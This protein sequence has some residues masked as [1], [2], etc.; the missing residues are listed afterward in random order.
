MMAPEELGRL[1]DE[2]SAA[3]VLFARQWTGAPE[4]VVQ[5][6]FVKRAGSAPAPPHAVAWLFTVVRRG[7]MTAAR[8][9]RRRRK[10]ESVA[11][12][13]APA[14]FAPTEGEGLDA[15]RA[16]SALAA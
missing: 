4:A 8:S 10:H 16:A 14:W 7:A 5:E 12:A 9:E 15:T 3:L 1:I 13:R 2:H 11:A 6:A